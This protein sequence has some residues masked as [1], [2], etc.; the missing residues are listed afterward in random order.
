MVSAI[1]SVIGMVIENFVD[2]PMHENG[3]KNIWNSK[4]LSI[5]S[6]VRIF[7]S[8]IETVL[9]YG[10]KT[11]KT[12]TTIINRLQQQPI[13]EENKPTPVEEEIRKRRRK[14]IGY[15]LRKSSNCITKQVLTWNP[16]EM[17]R[18]MPKST[19]RRQLEADMKRMNSNR[20]G[21]P[22]TGLDEEC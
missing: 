14:W 10:A 20:R 5:S 12:T 7:N 6:K 4:Q 18:A 9:L 19:L 22:R 2:L 13:V 21:L 15:T 16:V 11:R 3:V 17:E 1:I 8:N